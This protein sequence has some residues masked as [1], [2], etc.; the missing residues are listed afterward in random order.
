MLTEGC[1]LSVRMHSSDDWREYSKSLVIYYD[2]NINRFKKIFCIIIFLALAEIISIKDVGFM[3]Y[4][5]VHY[6]DC[7]FN[8][9]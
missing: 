1:R 6:I 5:Y 3:R 7:K 9:S 8:D 2:N 4:Y